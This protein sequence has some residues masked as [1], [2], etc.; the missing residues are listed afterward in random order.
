MSSLPIVK[1]KDATPF[2]TPFPSTI[3]LYIRKQQLR[4]QKVGRRILIKRSDLENFVKA[5]QIQD[6]KNDCVTVVSNL[7]GNRIYG[8]RASRL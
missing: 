7:S 4:P 1:S 8:Y 3:R 5:Q 2:P 6:S